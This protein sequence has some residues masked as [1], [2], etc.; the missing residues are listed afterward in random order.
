MSDTEFTTILNT[1]MPEYRVV[2]LIGSGN[3]GSVYKCERD[4]IYYAI[5]MI[6]VPP[7]EK[8]LQ[9]LLARSDE[10]A[11]E[12]Y[13]REKVGGYQNEIKVM[14]NLKG[15]RS[16]V[17]IEDYKIFQ[18]TNSSMWYI[19]I[20]M[21]LLTSL[22]EYT[23]THV[24][25]AAEVVSLGKDICDALTI[26]EKNGIIHRDVKPDNIM[27]HKEGAF[28]LG[29]F[30]IAR[31]LSQTTTG[32]IAGT[33]GFMAPEVSR[34]LEYNK[35]ADIYSLGI[36]LYY[37]LNNR[38]M[39]YVAPDDRSLSSE[40]NAIFKRLTENSILPPPPYAEANLA[41]VIQKA[42][43]YDKEDRYQTAAEMRQDLERVSRG[44]PVNVILESTGQ[45]GTIITKTPVIRNTEHPNTDTPF[46]GTMVDQ[47]NQKQKSKQDTVDFTAGTKKKHKGLTVAIAVACVALLA[48]GP[49]TGRSG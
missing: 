39:P 42:C 26:C 5:K 11:V 35:T 3:F 1:C 25:T 27:I 23:K 14:S 47:R 43:M 34:G 19:V 7:T 41:R 12:E 13:L 44:E 49:S 46:T 20:R 29:D 36:V 9:A 10:D 32:T 16:I 45:K 48:G 4:G 31:Q 21:E 40:Q 15:N 28:K 8:D 17:N 37:Y 22:T 24:L 38:K 6:T 18:L 30:G 2:E 33:E